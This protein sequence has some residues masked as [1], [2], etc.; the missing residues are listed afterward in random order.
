MSEAEVRASAAPEELAAGASAAPEEAAV[1]ADEVQTTATVQT[2]AAPAEPPSRPGVPAVAGVR[3]ELGADELLALLAAVFPPGTPCRHW[4]ACLDTI[5]PLAGGLPSDLAGW[6]DGRAWGAR[7]EVR[8][9]QATDGR[10]GALYLADGE[11]LPAGFAALDAD[12]RAVPS[13][14]AAGL[15]LWGTRRDDGRYHTTRL[16]RPLE[17]PGLGA[18]GREPRVPYRVLWGADGVVRFVRLALVEEG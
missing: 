7:A 17:Y 10:Y 18:S 6:S 13:E 5:G 4:C 2:S 11:T 12:L 15:Y 1:A 14:D 16:P 8:W 3:E 9:Q